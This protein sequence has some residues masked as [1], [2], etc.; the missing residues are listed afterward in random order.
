MEI[1]QDVLCHLLERAGKESTE[2]RQQRLQIFQGALL[3]HLSS[4]KT[5]YMLQRRTPH[6]PAAA[7]VMV[8]TPPVVAVG[9][10]D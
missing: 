6:P 9:G 1:L 7:M 2:Q 8:F 3:H 10:C 5:I 4:N